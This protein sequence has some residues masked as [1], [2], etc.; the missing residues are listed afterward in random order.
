MAICYNNTSG[1]AVNNNVSNTT[2]ARLFAHGTGNGASF[3]AIEAPVNNEL[4]EGETGVLTYNFY[5]RGIS[6]GSK[7]FASGRHGISIVCRVCPRRVYR[8]G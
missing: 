8:F 4:E 3:W 5:Y 6:V 2:N 1:T 7:E